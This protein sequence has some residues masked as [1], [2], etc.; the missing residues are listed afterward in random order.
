M[1]TIPDRPAS[2]LL[3]IDVQT[4]VLAGA[5]RREEVLV[6]DAHTTEDLSAYGAPAPEAVIAHTNLYWSMQSAPGRTAGTAPAAEVD[7]GPGS[8]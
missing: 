3:V 4:G 6:D 7:L 1:T 2:A 8:A 5:A